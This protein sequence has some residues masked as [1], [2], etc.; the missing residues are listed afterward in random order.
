MGCVKS[1]EADIQDK[2]IKTEL[3]PGLQLGRYVK[4]PTADNKHVSGSRRAPAGGVSGPWSH[5]C[6]L[7][8]CESTE[9]GAGRGRWGGSTGSGGNK[10]IMEKEREK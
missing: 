4:D 1:K 8:S 10:G 2:V 6:G 7:W 9:P 5:P 3:E